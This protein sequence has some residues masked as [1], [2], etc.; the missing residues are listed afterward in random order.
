MKDSCLQPKEEQAIFQGL[1][2]GVTSLAEVEE[3]T[4]S[5]YESEGSSFSA[6]VG[7]SYTS[8]TQVTGSYSLPINAPN[9]QHSP[10]LG[11]ELLL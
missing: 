7:S 9:L 8:P 5:P 10:R 3:I 11:L 2:V 4:S 6:S 1:G